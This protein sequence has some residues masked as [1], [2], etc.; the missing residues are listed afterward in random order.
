MSFC[1]PVEPRNK[2]VSQNRGGILESKEMLKVLEP[3]ENK[4]PRVGV[5]SKVNTRQVT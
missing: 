3:K 1:P 5:R 2:D 4:I